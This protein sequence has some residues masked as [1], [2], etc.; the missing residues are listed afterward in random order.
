MSC[1]GWIVDFDDWR[2][3]AGPRVNT[4]MTAD[5]I[6][7]GNMNMCIDRAGHGSEVVCVRSSPHG[8]ETSLSGTTRSSSLKRVYRPGSVVESTRV[9]LC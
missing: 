6:I 9:D 1:R 4:R 7:W 8:V 5:S 2:E 3:S